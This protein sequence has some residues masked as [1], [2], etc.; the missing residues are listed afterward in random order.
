MLSDTFPAAVQR[1]ESGVNSIDQLLLVSKLTFGTRVG[2][3]DAPLSCV[4]VCVFRLL[5]GGLDKLDPEPAGV[6]LRDAGRREQGERSHRDKLRRCQA[7]GGGG[8]RTGPLRPRK[9]VAPGKL[10]RHA[11]GPALKCNVELH[12]GAQATGVPWVEWVPTALVG[13]YSG[14]IGHSGCS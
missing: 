7:A 10:H 14:G 5:S 2:S 6:W 11:L 4:F 13:R 8:L 12:F 3:V 9:S 1:S